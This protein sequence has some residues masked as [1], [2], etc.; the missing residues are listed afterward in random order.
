MKNIAILASGN[1]SNAERIMEHFSTDGPGGDVA[2][3]VVLMSDNPAAFAL[4]RAARRGVPAE[5]L[6]RAEFADGRAAL[7]ILQRHE[8]DFVVLAGFLRLVPLNVTE[9]FRGRMVNIHPSLLPAHGG[10]GMYG[11]RVHEAVIAACECESGITVHHVNPR[12]DDGAMIAQFRCEVKPDDTPESLAARV[13]ELE[14]KHFPE[15]I[16]RL[17]RESK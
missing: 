13:H 14:H 16:E 10:R 17:L 15:V 2:R 8:V 9:A 11:A 3:V 7:E 5:I 12:F 4:E 6:T 1:G